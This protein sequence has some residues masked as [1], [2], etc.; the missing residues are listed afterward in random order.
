MKLPQKKVELYLQVKEKG[1]LS[2]LM[3]ST[4]LKDRSTMCLIMLGKKGTT[5]A[6][7]KAICKVLDNRLKTIEKL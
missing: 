2:D 4:G 3:K 6:R 5:L 1:I 7:V